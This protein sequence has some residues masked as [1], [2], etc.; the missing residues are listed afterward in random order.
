LAHGTFDSRS[1]D[2]PNQLFTT[3]ALENVTRMECRRVYGA[4]GIPDDD[5]ASMESI[6]ADVT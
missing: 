3:I 2:I 6:V 4:V 1:L 5:V